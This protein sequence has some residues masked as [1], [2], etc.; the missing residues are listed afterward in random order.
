MFEGFK[1]KCFQTW[2]SISHQIIQH[3]AEVNTFSDLQECLYADHLQKTI[4]KKSYF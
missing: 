1:E 4:E 3:E 2:N